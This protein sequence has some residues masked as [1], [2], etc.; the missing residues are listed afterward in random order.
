MAN[1]GRDSPISMDGPNPPAMPLFPLAIRE[2]QE[3]DELM[4]VLE[5]YPPMERGSLMEELLYIRQIFQE[6]E[7]ILQQHCD[8][9][10][11]EFPRPPDTPPAP[12]EYHCIVNLQS[13]Q[14]QP[15]RP[16]VIW[17]CRTCHKIFH[18]ARIFNLRRDTIRREVNR[19]QGFPP[20]I[21]PEFDRR[22]THPLQPPFPLPELENIVDALRDEA[23]HSDS[24]EPA[25]RDPPIIP[26]VLPVLNGN[27]T[28]Y[29]NHLPR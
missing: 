8:Y 1:P 28:S 22:L 11:Y 26:G 9:S 15:A 24:P 17:Y 27:S 6:L 2:I 12:L 29:P 4:D 10:A 14:L 13:S 18:Y 21:V 3:E 5:E 16:L 7:R 23:A 19:Q 20:P 25:E